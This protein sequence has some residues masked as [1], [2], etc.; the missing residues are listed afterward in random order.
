MASSREIRPDIFTRACLLVAAALPWYAVFSGLFGLYFYVLLAVSQ[1][2]SLLGG[3]A[4]EV[5]SVV[6][7]A[8][9][10]AAALP[11]GLLL[12]LAMPAGLA[13]AAFRHSPRGLFGTAVRWSCVVSMA[14]AALHAAIIIAGYMGDLATR[15]FAEPWWSGLLNGVALLVGLAATWRAWRNIHGQARHGHG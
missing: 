9:T 5:A 15:G 4:G 10:L 7:F 6:L 2:G 13:C 12:L 1:V 3:T 8:V 11:L 14:F